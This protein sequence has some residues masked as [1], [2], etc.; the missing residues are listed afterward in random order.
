MKMS[1]FSHWISL[2]KAFCGRVGH[3]ARFRTS[4]TIGQEEAKKEAWQLAVAGFR[5]RAVSEILGASA[6][7]LS[8]RDDR[9]VVVFDGWIDFGEWAGLNCGRC[10]RCGVQHLGQG[11]Q[12]PCGI[13]PRLLGRF[14]IDG[15]LPLATF[16]LIGGV[17]HEQGFELVGVPPVECSQIVRSWVKTGD[18]GIRDAKS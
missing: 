14:I 1:G 3:S 9:G 17:V 12:V 15:R 5:A 16:V 2:G 11:R 13:L 18:R 7:A 4:R 6:V 8:D 10:M